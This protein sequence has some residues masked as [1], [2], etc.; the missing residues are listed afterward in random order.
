MSVVK[1]MKKLILFFV[2]LQS[3]MFGCSHGEKTFESGYDDGYAE[4]FN[5]HCKIRETVIYGHWDSAEYK[6]GYYI[7]RDDGVQA[8]INHKKNINKN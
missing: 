3:L 4:G 6:K 7:G 1:A 8:C 2:L 5:T